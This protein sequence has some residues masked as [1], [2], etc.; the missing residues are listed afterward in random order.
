MPMPK[1][2][3]VPPIGTLRPKVSPA[4]GTPAP[5]ALAPQTAPAPKPAAPAPLPSK[6]TPPVQ[7]FGHTP[8][9]WPDGSTAAKDFPS[10]IPRVP[11][12]R[13]AVFSM[14]GATAMAYFTCDAGPRTVADLYGRFAQSDGWELVPFPGPPLEQEAILMARKEDWTLR[15]DAGV[16][17][18]THQTEAFVLVMLKPLPPEPAAGKAKP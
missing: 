16:N 4:A 6:P 1:P 15:V 13:L 18:L 12:A 9:P 7:A 8:P 10:H 11:A 17:P 14:S 5:T 2:L 3:G